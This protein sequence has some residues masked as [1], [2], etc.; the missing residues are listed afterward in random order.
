MRDA[1]EWD[2]RDIDWSCNV[3]GED[4]KVSSS[5]RFHVLVEPCKT[6]LQNAREDGYHEGY[7]ERDVEI[8]KGQIEGRD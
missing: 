4:L 5:G 2:P 3:C 7:S 1:D 6:C 8:Y